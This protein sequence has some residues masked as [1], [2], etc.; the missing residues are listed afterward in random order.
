MQVFQNERSFSGRCKQMFRHSII[1]LLLALP[2]TAAIYAHESRATNP[3]QTIRVDV[4]VVLV[5]ATVSDSKGRMVLGLQPENFRISEDK[6]EQKVEY[7]STEDSPMSIGLI[8]DA[9]GS[10]ANKISSSRQAA[11][12]FLRMGNR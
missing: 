1:A 3:D 4:D 10:M 11:A 8:F 9:T 7:F 6:V 5:N 2:A 12:S